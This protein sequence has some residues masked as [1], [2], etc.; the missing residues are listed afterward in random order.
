[1]LTAGTTGVVIVIV[2]L[3]VIS[4]EQVVMVLVAVAVY[5]TAVVNVPKLIAAPVPGVVAT[6]EA[7]SQRL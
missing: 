7:P 4:D 6:I 2:A 1:M 5:V 3:P